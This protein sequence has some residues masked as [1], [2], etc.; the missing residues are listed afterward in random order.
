L[1]RSHGP[2]RPLLARRAARLPSHRSLLGLL[3]QKWP[4]VGLLQGM[5]LIRN[6]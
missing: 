4:P 1:G 6:Y 3:L 2:P 5:D